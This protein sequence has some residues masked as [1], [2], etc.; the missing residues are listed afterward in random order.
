MGFEAIAEVVE[1]P[2]LA[3]EIGSSGEDKGRAA[4]EVVV[5]AEEQRSAGK[6]TLPAGER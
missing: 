6:A 4:A 1:V 2:R 5:S 3:C